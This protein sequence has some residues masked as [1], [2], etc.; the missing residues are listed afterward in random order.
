MA[1]GWWLLAEAW[2]LVPGG[3]LCWLAWYSVLISRETTLNPNKRHGISGKSAHKKR[4][5]NVAIKPDKNCM[6]SFGNFPR[7]IW[8]KVAS[9]ALKVRVK[10]LDFSDKRT[11]VPDNKP[12][13]R[14]VSPYLT[15]KISRTGFIAI[16]IFQKSELVDYFFCEKL[17]S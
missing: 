2:C 1:G 5:K 3:L 7:Q 15:V 13:H 10:I 11:I 4:K 14:F 6:W 9:E 17:L 8:Q 16:I 12:K